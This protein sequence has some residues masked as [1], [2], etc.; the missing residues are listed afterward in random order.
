MAEIVQKITPCLWFNEVAKEAVDFY[1]SV[2]PN[3]RVTHTSYYPKNA[4]EGLADFQLNMAGKELTIDFELNGVPFTALN[5]GPEFTFSEAIS[6]MI[7]C[8]DQEEIDYYWDKLSAVPEAEQCGWL[9]D[10][11]GLSWQVIPANMEELMQRPNAFE[12]LMEMHK[13]EIDK[14]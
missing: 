11:Y 9:K 13:L 7:T 8:E 3:S 10:R 4:E 6:F 12:H 14:F 1:L 2:F 5:A